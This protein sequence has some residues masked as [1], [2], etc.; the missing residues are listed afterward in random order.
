MGHG[1]LWKGSDDSASG[2]RTPPGAGALGPAQAAHSRPL[3]WDGSL[4]SGRTDTLVS[5]GILAQRKHS[6][7][8]REAPSPRQHSGA[9]SPRLPLRKDTRAALASPGARLPLHRPQEEHVPPAPVRLNGQGRRYSHGARVGRLW[10]TSSGGGGG[11]NCPG[12]DGAVWAPPL[13]RAGQNTEPHAM[14]RQGTRAGVQGTPASARPPAR[15]R[16]GSCES[17]GSC[18]GESRA[19]SRPGGGPR[20]CPSCARAGK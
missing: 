2:V 20:G 5:T 8:R 7:R 18:V 13:Q 10:R 12:R 4:S 3:C 16:L 17:E 11:P 15:R 9:A 19:R 1:G 14:P 6:L